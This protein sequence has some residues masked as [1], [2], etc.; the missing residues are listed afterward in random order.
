MIFCL[1][2]HK[3]A[4]SS[5]EKAL[6][7]VGHQLE[8]D[9]PNEERT[10]EAARLLVKEHSNSNRRGFPFN[11]Y[12]EELLKLHPDAFFILTLRD[13]DDWFNSI[14]RNFNHVHVDNH[15]WFY[16]IPGIDKDIYIERHKA[17]VKHV[18]KV[19]KGNPN[20][21][22]MDIPAGDGWEKLGT[23]LK[24]KTPNQPFPHTNK[25]PVTI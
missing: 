24:T 1:G 25:T 21:I 9:V 7:M 14:K 4:T 11:A 8:Q 6:N 2:L 19:M 13:Y 3:T 20:Y 22:E 5:L 15:E 16:G 18:R 23:L 10:N 17:H 12:P